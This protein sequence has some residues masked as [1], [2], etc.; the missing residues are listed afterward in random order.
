MQHS[1]LPVTD[2]PIFLIPRPKLIKI[3]LQKLSLLRT[4]VFTVLRTLY[5]VPKKHFYRSTIV[6]RTSK[7]YFSLN[8]VVSILSLFFYC[9][10]Y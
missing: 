3:I 2:T 8:L 7:K 6:K 9:F 4:L 10:C 1:H 5:A